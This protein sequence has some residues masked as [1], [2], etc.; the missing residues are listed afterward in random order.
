M[1]HWQQDSP[2][3]GALPG[4]DSRCVSCTGRNQSACRDIEAASACRDRPWAF[5]GG[6]FRS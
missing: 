3:C 1:A 2:A 5:P 4:P 6:N